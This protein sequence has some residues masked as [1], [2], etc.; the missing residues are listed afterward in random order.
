MSM[1]SI[2]RRHSQVIFMHSRAKGNSTLQK[3]PK[4]VM[5]ME[6]MYKPTTESANY[7]KFDRIRDHCN[8]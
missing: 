8:D 1:M 2:S 6:A 4:C 3:H 5:N 7:Q